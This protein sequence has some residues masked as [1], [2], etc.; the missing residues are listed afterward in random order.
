MDICKRIKNININILLD[1]LLFITLIIQD[2]DYL[3]I[4]GTQMYKYIILLMFLVLIF[5]I[6]KN[7]KSIK[8]NK[9]YLLFL[10]LIYIYL[11]L[12]SF[13]K[14]IIVP[15]IFFVIEIFTF[16]LY[17]QSKKNIEEL[18]RS[19][20]KI[21]LTA[22][23]VISLFGI[24][25]FISY[26]LNIHFIYEYLSQNLVYLYEGRFSS[27]YT[28]P[29]HLCTI[30]SAGMFISM[31]NIGSNKG[32]INYLFLVLTLFV[33]LLSGSVV[34]YAS[35]F[36]FMMLFYYL[37]FFGK[38]MKVNFKKSKVGI[39]TL[40]ILLISTLV[41]CFFQK[42]IIL[43]AI[44]KVNALFSKN[45]YTV[46]EQDKNI[47]VDNNMD[48]NI[49]NINDITTI[50]NTNNIDVENPENNTSLQNEI[51]HTQ[52]SN[53]SAYAM[54]SNYYIGIEKLKDKYLLGTG[55]FTHIVYYDKYMQRIYPNGYVRINYTDACSMFLR[56]F[57]EFGI[58]GLIGF[59]G[60]LIYLL[61]YGIK[62]KQYFLLFM[63]VIFITQSMRLGE[64]NWILNC[65]SFVVMLSYIKMKD[66]YEYNLKIS[67]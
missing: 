29:A 16:S 37:A 31:Y 5:N 55:M 24:I 47:N 19:L 1:V 42:Q 56:I 33:G 30:I 32:K 51:M 21:I 54:K 22:S 39:L 64:Y 28:E 50:E 27:I 52:L 26:K 46:V 25:Q 49:D 60:I 15:S 38:K 4:F 41:F 65:L 35:I 20:S 36:L 63:L 3:R 2:I 58:I 10:V 57:S 11:Y 45:K 53:G 48:N 14:T 18:N 61:I 7:K 43:N 23:I 59:I 40:T 17:I 66:K 67:N 9:I 44:D 12:L 8:I 6:I 13:C 62:S 34:V